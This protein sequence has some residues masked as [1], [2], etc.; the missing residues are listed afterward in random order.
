[1]RLFYARKRET[2]GIYIQ[3]IKENSE[4]EAT[5]SFSLKLLPFGKLKSDR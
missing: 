4:Q 3:I 1:V 2:A 5:Q